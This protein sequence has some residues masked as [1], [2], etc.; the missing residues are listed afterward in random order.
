MTLP[1]LPLV[2]GA[3]FCSN[4]FMEWVQRCNR[5]AQYYKLNNRVS[6]GE[7][8]ALTFGTHLHSAFEMHY[9]LQEFDLSPSEI[10]ARVAAMLCEEFQKEPI[11]ESDFRTLNWAIEI[12]ERFAKKYEWEEFDLMRFEEK[13]KCKYCEGEG[14]KVDEVRGLVECPWC[15]GTGFSSI[16]CE[17][18][19]V[20]KLFDYEP[21]DKEVFFANTGLFRF[22]VY[23]HGYIDLITSINNFIYPLDF[24][25]TAVLGN[26]FWDDKKMS[27]Q[28]KGYCFSP[29]TEL[30]TK[31]GWKAISQLSKGELVAQ[32][33]KG[34]IEFVAPTAYF[35]REVKEK[36]I[37]HYGAI[38]TFTTNE[39]RFVVKDRQAKVFKEF[40]ASTLPLSQN[41][42]VP[43]AGIIKN[44]NSSLTSIELQAIAMLQADGCLRANGTV[45]F[46]F[47]KERKIERCRAFLQKQNQSFSESTKDGIVSFYVH[48]DN[49]LFNKAANLLGQNKEFGSWLLDCGANELTVFLEEVV[50]WDGSDRGPKGFIYSSVSKNN[51]EWVQTIAA[52][53]GRRATIHTQDNNGVTQWRTNV[54]FKGEQGLGGVSRV[55]VDYDGSV[56]C[57]NVPSSYL[58]T[59]LR[60]KISV[61]GNCYGFQETTG[62]KVKGYITRGI[63]TTSM[64]D[65]VRNGT[66][67]TRGE[68][69]GLV[70]S[71]ENW[72]KETLPDDQKEI[73]GEGE[74][75]DWKEN[76]IA[77]IEEFL[78]HYNR[79]KMPRST[80]ACT[81]KF[82]RCQYFEVC[83]T[84]PV[85]D[86]ELILGSGLYKDKENKT[87][88]LVPIEQTKTT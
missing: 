12:Y 15:N 53:C 26:S 5:G 79:G 56:F 45:S 88:N 63:R 24:K 36:L 8:A 80:T 60:N 75:E 23:Y 71:Q 58:V 65:N 10:S 1:P 81:G 6:S 16:M 67:A 69:K 27:A 9:R 17:V 51:V 43:C 87:P 42:R 20:V 35:K 37:L 46:T 38:E 44:L 74:L 52:L 40:T 50:H 11:E 77:L 30:L 49:A 2:N 72:W 62:H 21:D 84:F 76:T 70:T 19:F 83:N 47:K 28:P 14:G 68:N 73:L 57:V 59:K 34:T 39:H 13:V 4:S 33:N 54:V 7:T 66:P 61:L 86:R 78:W 55:E 18:P 22:P 31:S 32:W 85:S 82:G 25:S 29:D 3:L 64:P 48:Q 41:Y